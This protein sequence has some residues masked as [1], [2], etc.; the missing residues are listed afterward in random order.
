[1]DEAK[2]EGRCLCRKGIRLCFRA[3]AGGSLP[4]QPAPLVGGLFLK[5]KHSSSVAG[6]GRRIF[7]GDVICLSHPCISSSHAILTPLRLQE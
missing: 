5:N 1:M 4:L 7:L 2:R 6:V 3:A